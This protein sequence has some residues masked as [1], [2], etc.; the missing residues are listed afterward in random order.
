MSLK[1]IDHHTHTQASPDAD[2]NLSMEDYIHK[3]KAQGYPGVMFT[4]HVDYDFVSPLFLEIIDYN[5]YH[6]KIVELRK[7]HNFDVRMG[8]EIGY[9]PHLNERIK[10]LVN[11]HPFDFVIAS[12]HL[13]DGL[14]LY[15]GDFFIGKTQEEAYQRY[16]E[17]VLYAVNNFT[18]YDVYGHL[19]YIIRYGKFER[20]MYDF[21]T[22]KP[23]IEDILKVIIKNG[24]GIELNTSGLR[25]QLGVTH[26]RL[27]LLELYK[28]LG[29]T[30]ITLGSDAHYLKDYQA[31]FELGISLL[32]KAGFTHVTEYKERTPYFIEISQ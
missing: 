4:D 14:D 5:I 22:F 12:T 7:T 25:Y 16:F 23:I 32:K 29:G 3:A 6:Q 31:D 15:N 10:T 19:D 30:I 13:C 2:P 27:E 20:K 1:L 8:V 9:Q 28:N 11:N 26:P 24:K 17:I 21:N 18:D